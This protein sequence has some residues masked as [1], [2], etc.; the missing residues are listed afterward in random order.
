MSDF[1]A[2]PRVRDSTLLSL[3]HYE[4]RECAVCGAERREVN[5]HGEYVAR[6]SLHHIRK[7]PRD[8]VRGN[9][10]MLCGDGVIGCHGRVEAHDK[11]TLVLLVTALLAERPD[12]IEYLDRRLEL[13]GAE[14]RG[15]EWLDRLC[16]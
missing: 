14:E 8:D 2:P 9:L 12:V 4:W 16:A 11:E 5:D 13:E 3:L 6:L 1:K 10:V 7:H 15:V